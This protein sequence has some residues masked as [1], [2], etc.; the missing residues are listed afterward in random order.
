M[1]LRRIYYDKLTD[2]IL[3]SFMIQGD[4]LHYPQIKDFE[5][6]PALQGR[7]ADDIAVMEWTEP[8]PVIEDNFARATIYGI[9]NGEL[10]FDFTPL[11]EPDP[12]PPDE[13]A[14]ALE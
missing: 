12:T 5:V 14:Q 6:Q 7:T 1:F 9:I 10:T 2:E 8:N 11:P 4:I 3:Y 13:M